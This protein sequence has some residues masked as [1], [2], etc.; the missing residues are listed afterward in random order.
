MCDKMFL[1][2]LL[3]NFLKVCMIIGLSLALSACDN[4]ENEMLVNR[5][6]HLEE[7]IDTLLEQNGINSNDITNNDTVIND[8]EGST[9]VDTSEIEK[10]LD[11]YQTEA[12]DIST[13]IDNLKVSSNRS[14]TI[15][16]FFKWKATI[17]ELDTK[18]DYYENELESLY[19]N[20]ELSYSDYRKYDRE[21][22]DIENIL[23]KAENNLEYKTNYDD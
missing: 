10:N 1:V 18:L 4:E 5:V 6:N 7:K 16:L 2:I 15:N 22:E 14:E 17:E 12:N 8:G 11:N 9:T 13:D 23:D 20:N 3:K 21:I 19:L